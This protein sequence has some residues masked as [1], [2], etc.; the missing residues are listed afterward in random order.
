MNNG[1]WSMTDYNGGNRSKLAA[2]LVDSKKLGLA[3]T[4]AGNTVASN[5]D[6]N[7]TPT[8]DS[9]KWKIAGKDSGNSELPI[10]VGAIASSVS[11][12]IDSAVTA[13]NV[14]FT[15]AWAE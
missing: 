13:A 3:L 9:S 6:G 12:N 8:I 15:V 14:I 2:S 7:Q 10:S 1:D 4:A 11:K 5:K